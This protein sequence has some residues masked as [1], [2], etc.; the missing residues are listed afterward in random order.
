MASFI[1]QT[2]AAAIFHGR[3][4]PSLGVNA[5]SAISAIARRLGY[6]VNRKAVPAH[7]IRQRFSTDLN[8]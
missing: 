7:D 4:M 6:P 5:R 1:R 2:H 8:F 3:D